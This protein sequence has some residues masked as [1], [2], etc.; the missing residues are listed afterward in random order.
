MRAAAA[1]EMPADAE[2]VAILR[3]LAQADDE[4]RVR[5]AAASRLHE[6]DDLVV[7]ARA[8]RDEEHR[9]ELQERLVEIAN[10]AAATDA[11]AAVALTGLTDQKQLAAVARTSPH[12]N[13]RAAALGQIHEAKILGAVARGAAHPETALD[14]VNR[15][16]DV[17]ELVP[18]AA[19][20]EHKDAGIAALE[21]AAAADPAGA[22]EMLDGVA[23]RAKN[24]SVAKRARTMVQTILDTEAAQRAALEQW[25]QRV[26]AVLAR[27]EA[28]GAA[29]SRPDTP[30]ELGRAD[31]EWRELS[32]GGTF[33]LDP[34]TAA[35]YASLVEAARQR[36]AEHERAEQER[37]AE[38]ERLLALHASRM[39]ICER[40]EAASDEEAAAALE[41]ARAEWEGL[42]PAAEGELEYE[43]VRRRFEEA[44]RRTR[45]RHENRAERQRISARLDELAQDA[46]RVAS[47]EEITDAAWQQLTG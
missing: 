36:L 39:A 42:P 34:D 18:I 29:P 5:R 37:R 30:A 13:V 25:Q 27:L 47:A 12:E 8:E 11:A 31:A 21:K 44:C 2:H 6:A 9:R 33:E 32:A 22:R 41:I 15:I 24:K 16:A 19:K 26:A 40:L 43:A 3:D 4:V 23:A 45:E 7:L 38:A 17:A 46:Q 35:R 1:A 28:I 20:T 14:A 10:A